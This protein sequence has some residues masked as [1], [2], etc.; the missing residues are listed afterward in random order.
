MR[1]RIEDVLELPAR[2]VIETIASH[3]GHDK[4]IVAR[5]DTAEVVM[6]R[7]ESR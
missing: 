4:R 6:D 1:Y 3:P 2:F 5:P 7:I